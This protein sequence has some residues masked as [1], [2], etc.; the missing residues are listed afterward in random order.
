MHMPVELRRLPCSGYTWVHADYLCCETLALNSP[1][2]VQISDVLNFTSSHSE[3]LYIAL[4]YSR[5]SSYRHNIAIDNAFRGVY[6]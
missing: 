3:G 4:G 5:V 1:Q 2:Y 6:T